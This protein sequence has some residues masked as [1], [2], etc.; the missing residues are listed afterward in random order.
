IK[1]EVL[2][3]SNFIPVLL[4][5]TSSEEEG[6]ETPWALAAAS[7]DVLSEISFLRA[8]APAPR[9]HQVNLLHPGDLLLLLEPEG[10]AIVHHGGP[11]ISPPQTYALRTSGNWEPVTWAFTPGRSAARA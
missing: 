5:G 2:T 11:A 3:P 7:H 4:P 10:I 6:T 9:A 1:E 8:T